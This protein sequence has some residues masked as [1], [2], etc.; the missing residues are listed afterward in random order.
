MSESV[1]IPRYEKTQISSIWSETARAS[2]YLT[3]ELALLKSLEQNK[4]IP[5]GTFDQ[6]K[7]VKVSID[8]INEIE[9]EVKHD[10][11][12]FCTSITE[13]VNKEYSKY[14]HYGVTSS[15]I[16]DTAQNLQIKDSLSI[17]IPSYKKL[18]ASLI[19]LANRTID[20]VGVGRSHGMFAEALSYGQ[21]FLGHYS[22]FA[23]KLKD[24]EDFYSTELTGQL[25][26]AVGNYTILNFDI[27]HDA[28]TQLGLKTEPVSTQ[29]IPRDRIAKL[30]SILSRIAGAIERIS[31][32]IRH[33]HRSEVGEVYE[34]FTKGQKGSSTMP[35]KKNPI[36][37]ENLTGI[38]RVIRSHSLIAMENN[39]LWHERDIS[40]SSAERL[41]L[42]DSLGLTLYALERL[43]STL[44][45]L[46]I[47][48]DIIENRSDHSGGVLSSFYLHELIRKT[49]L[50]REDIYKIIQ[51]SA[52]ENQET[53][54]DIDSIINRNLTRDGIKQQVDKVD[55]EKLKDKYRKSALEV[56]ERVLSTYPL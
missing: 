16:I 6:F 44:D 17:I 56:R 1:M 9:K 11:I 49:S 40:H 25:S 10:I 47:K 31:V 41:Y 18:N 43:T 48:E 27:E 22:E 51:E 7:N 20:V 3:V 8:R 37:T 55:M 24:L 15:D 13:Q 19:H 46:I 2:Y 34:G 53:S 45:N 35:H 29:V 30:A 39:I 5:S 21:K 50:T 4:V 23:R 33:L 38:A 54:E 52:F 42:P 14:F 32:E 36:S 26:G 12:A 28:L